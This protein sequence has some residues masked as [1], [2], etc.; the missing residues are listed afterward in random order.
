MEQPGVQQVFFQHIRNNLP[1]HLS[2]V[3]EI[4]ELLN[5]SND[6]AYRRIRGEK[7]V[8]FEELRTLCA[9]FKISLDQLLYL[10]SE[11]VIFTGRYADHST[12]SFEEY[13]EKNILGQ[14]QFM[15]S[16]ERKELMYLNKD[17]PIF[18]LLNFH[19]LAAFKFFFWMKTILQY[20]SLG[21]SHFRPD[22]FMDPLEKIGKKIVEE[23]NRLPSQ[24]IWNVESINSTIHQIEY[25]KDTR[26]FSSTEDIIKLYDAL[27]KTIN[28]IE[29]QAEV[30]Y[31]FT[32]D[33]KI[34]NPKA[35][36]KMFVNEF[37]L[38]DNTLMAL[39]NDTKIA[40]INHSVINVVWTKDTAFAEHTYQ[41]FQNIIRR[42]TLVS[43]VGEKERSR[44]FNGM[45]EK[46]H[47]RKKAAEHYS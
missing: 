31:K 25:Y 9:H 16:F 39:L 18:H 35:S 11:S 22:E 2:F 36:Y 38:G 41:H 34:S 13:L 24:E 4:A 1:A 15:N 27:E 32:L 23:Y 29:K 14:L 20:P 42:S 7:E 6:S 43:D 10:N 5:I 8:S 19:E 17:I 3:D 26:A 45:R 12:F 46:I 28:H 47:H 21:G 30:G 40:Y 44:F 33:G 37:I